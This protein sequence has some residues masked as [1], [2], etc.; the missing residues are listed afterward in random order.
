M[1][2]S[3]V[4]AFRALVMIACMIAIPSVALFWKSWPDIL[5][6]ALNGRLP[7][8]VMAEADEPTYRHEAPR[9]GEA[10]P[11]ASYGE[12]PPCA[13]S[14]EA[15]PPSPYGQAPP[16]TPSADGGPYAPPATAAPVADVA[17]ASWNPP[18]HAQP[19]AP[20]YPHAV[21]PAHGSSVG[22]APGSS[23]APP[24][25]VPSVYAGASQPDRYAGASD[26]APP[27]NAGAVPEA[28]T[29]PLEEAPPY[30]TAPATGA[31]QAP[32]P[33]AAHALFEEAPPA[34]APP[35]D[36]PLRRGERSPEQ[37]GRREPGSVGAYPS[38]ANEPA[39]HHA[40]LETPEAS[41]QSLVAQ[42]A[43]E[44]APPAAS[45]PESQPPASAAPGVGAPP[46]QT[47][48]HPNLTSP[49]FNNPTSSD[50]RQMHPAL[51][52]PQGT[53]APG[54]TPAQI[55]APNVTGPLVPPRQEAGLD[56][57]AAMERRLRELGATYYLLETWGESGELYRFH[58]K[59]ALSDNPR[60]NRH[61]EATDAEAMVAMQRV[62][63]QVEAWRSGRAP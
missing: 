30:S 43:Y 42:Q 36:Q 9:G 50:N 16:F 58:A 63:D 51:T 25:G 4:V 27:W 6:A 54:Q 10:P 15:A 52:A 8:L 61:F 13:P 44:A 1:R 41:S 32:S 40:P 19:P 57:F 46:W 18:P 31:V 47:Q 38:R 48:M 3:A 56:R 20:Q 22:D 26:D 33:P 37:F 60:Y 2:S 59:M 23:A 14:A 29:S 21:L 12:A 35:Y 49:N 11:Y 62:L 55:A 28:T 24:G 34:E 45:Q 17:H 5:E 39:A 53:S 7:K